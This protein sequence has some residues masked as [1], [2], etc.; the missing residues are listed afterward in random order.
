[1]AF[2][3]TARTY[4]IPARPH[5]A[6]YVMH[7]AITLALVLLASCSSAPAIP[8]D[9][10][11][12]ARAGSPADET[13]VCA[14]DNAD[15]GVYLVIYQGRE[16]FIRR[17]PGLYALHAAAADPTGSYMWLITIGEGHPWLTVIDI[18]SMA[19]DGVH[20]D[21]E[22]MVILDPYPGWIEARF[23]GN[24]LYVRSDI[25]LLLESE[26]RDESSNY[27]VEYTFRLDMESGRL[28][29]AEAALFK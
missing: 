20:D 25:N 17:A 28:I 4:N 27:E 14:L 29:P 21:P 9:S 16:T 10:M 23:N 24:Q 1:M 19:R 2:T 18:G 5:R 3:M 22:P 11:P 15:Q 13:I 26:L 6:G 8:E 7:I 12:C